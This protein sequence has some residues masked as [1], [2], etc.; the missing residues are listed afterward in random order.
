MRLAAGT[1]RRYI[2]TTLPLFTTSTSNK[3]AGNIQH[4]TDS[5]AK[6]VD[7]T[8]APDH[9][10]YRM[11]PATENVQKPYEAP[12]GEWSRAGVKTSEYVK[13]NKDGGPG[14]RK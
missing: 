9:Q 2:H 4:T 5:Y 13:G 11:D 12:S 1:S 7:N 14:Q 6:D 8:P 10:V 3:D